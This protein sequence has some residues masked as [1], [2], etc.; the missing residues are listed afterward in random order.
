[1]L[2]LLML[3]GVGCA[4]QSPAPG[5]LPLPSSANAD[6]RLAAL[7]ED[8]VGEASQ[9][10]FPVG[11][12][13]V[14]EITVPDLPEL[15]ERSA[16]VGGDGNIE[17]PLVGVLGV[18]GRTEQEV[19]GLLRARLE[20]SVMHDPSV[21]VFVREYR[22]RIVGVIGAVAKPGFHA[23]SSRDDTI[24]DALTLAGGLNDKAA[25]H[26]FFMPA[27][28]GKPGSVAPALV[29]ASALAD[30]QRG[31]PIAIELSSLSEGGNPM[32]LGMPVR[33]GDVILV[34]ERGEVLVKGWVREPG[35]HPISPR[36]TVLG[37]IVAAG[38]PR[39]AADRD[40]IELIRTNGDGRKVGQVFALERLER[41][42]QADIP[43]QAGDVI[44]VTASPPKAVAYT[45]YEFARSIVN[46][47]FGR[48]W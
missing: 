38:G 9:F 36:L 42:E 13:D 5:E 8:R 47:G 2:P 46:I 19:T 29:A 15:E 37:A 11:P 23:L 31:N 32:Y 26:L 30:P 4:S 16:R 44:N 48:T 35:S 33:P 18:A 21:S 43:V 17:L 27:A 34:P 20:A 6:P 41:G 24:L 45:V 10:D 39:F 28:S 1:L 12:G 3:L 7:W 25:L 40:E 22:S 14:L